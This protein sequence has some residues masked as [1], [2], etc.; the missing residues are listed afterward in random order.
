[1][2]KNN[3]VQIR[4]KINKQVHFFQSKVRKKRVILKFN[5]INFF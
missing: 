4:E 1:M 5:V 2:F 3:H